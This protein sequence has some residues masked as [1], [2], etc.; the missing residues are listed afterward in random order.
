MSFQRQLTTL[1]I[2]QSVDVRSWER[3]LTVEVR[4]SPALFVVVRVVRPPVLFP[5]EVL[6]PPDVPFEAPPPRVELPAPTPVELL[7]PA[8]RPPVVEFTPDGLPVD[9]A[10]ATPAMVE[11]VPGPVATRTVLVPDVVAVTVVE[12]SLELAAATWICER[13]SLKEQE[14]DTYSCRSQFQR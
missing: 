4:V 9:P 7:D 2:S 6:L 5:P 13:D 8:P 12:A 14:I 1:S 3:I 11:V 10:P